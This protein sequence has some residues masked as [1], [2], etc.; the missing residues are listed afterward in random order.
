[1]SQFE[2]DCL[3][4]P[5]FEV[6][7]RGSVDDVEESDPLSSMTECLSMSFQCDEE[8]ASQSHAFSN[9]V[10]STMTQSHAGKSYGWESRMVGKVGEWTEVQNAN[11][12][13]PPDLLHKMNS[14]GNHCV[15]SGGV[16]LVHNGY[17]SRRGP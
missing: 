2:H 17:W 1:M 10:T 16:V 7:Q 9:A 14:I 12:P 5:S 13:P 3:N 8:A 4:V 15:F 6:I 11:G